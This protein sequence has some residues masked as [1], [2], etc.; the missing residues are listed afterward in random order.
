MVCNSQDSLGIACTQPPLIAAQGTVHKQFDIINID[1]S[2]L[3]RVAGAIARQHGDKG[4]A[5]TIQLTLTGSGGQSFGCFNIQVRVHVHSLRVQ[6]FAWL[7]AVHGKWKLKGCRG[8]VCGG[9]MYR[10]QG[11]YNVPTRDR[12]LSYLALPHDS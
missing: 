4:F 5:G 1:R 2:A 3:G 12:A 11:C 6:G 7:W 10:N 9:L 8:S